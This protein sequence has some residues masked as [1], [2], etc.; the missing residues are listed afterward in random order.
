MSKR[1]YT[2]SLVNPQV[3]NEKGR[4]GKPPLLLT[5]S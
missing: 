4:L 5:T 2:A 1:D 3:K